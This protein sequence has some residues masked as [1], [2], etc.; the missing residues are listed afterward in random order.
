MV[1]TGSRGQGEIGVI[2]LLALNF[3]QAKCSPVVQYNTVPIVNNNVL[4]T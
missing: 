4:C 2:N 1:V 3:S